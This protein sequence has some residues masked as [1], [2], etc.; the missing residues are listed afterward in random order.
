MLVIVL[1]L[2]LSYDVAKVRCLKVA[3]VRV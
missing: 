1:K 3:L 2:I